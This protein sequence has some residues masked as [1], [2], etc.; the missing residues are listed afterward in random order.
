MYCMYDLTCMYV[1]VLD[2]N[3]VRFAGFANLITK[4]GESP[5][6]ELER[7]VTTLHTYLQTYIHTHTVLVCFVGKESQSEGGLQ[8]G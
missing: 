2:N 3:R 6:F 4:I 8:G 5:M 7:Q 1:C